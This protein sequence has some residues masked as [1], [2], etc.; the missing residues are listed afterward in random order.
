MNSDIPTLWGSLRLEFWPENYSEVFS[1]LYLLHYFAWLVNK[2]TID[3]KVPSLPAKI[4]CAMGCSE[5]FESSLELHFQDVLL[6]SPPRPA[7]SPT[8]RTN[9]SCGSS[10]GTKAQRGKKFTTQSTIRLPGVMHNNK[11]TFYFI[12][13]S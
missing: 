10:L 4:R 2:F 6:S 1:S 12:H 7:R 8:F 13:L 9:A 5:L 11:F 3:P